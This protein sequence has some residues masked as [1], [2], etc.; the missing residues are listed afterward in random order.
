MLRKLAAPT[1]DAAALARVLGEPD[2]GGFEVNVLTDADSYQVTQAVEGL[3][4]D[5]E[6]SDLVLLHFSCHGIKDDSGEL[7]LAASN[8]V[9]N[10]LVSTAVDAAMVSRLIQRSR[11]QRVVLL[12][13]CCYGGAFERGVVARAGGEVD[14]GAQ[15]TQHS[16]PGGGRGRVV[17]TASSA[18]EYAF[19]GATL[20]DDSRGPTPSL[21]TG[22]LVEGITSGE[23]DRNQDG[24]VGLDEL[25]DYIHAKVQARTPNQ[26][27]C[28][29]EFGVQG[30][31]YIARNPR[32]KILPAQLPDELLEMVAHPNAS[33]RLAAVADLDRL[34]GGDN[35]RLAAAARLALQELRDDDSRRVSAAAIIAQERTTLRI[36]PTQI[37][38]G[39][40]PIGSRPH[41][42]VRVDGGPLAVASSIDVTHEHLNARF[43]GSILTVTATADQPGPL[44]GHVRLSG[45]AGEAT[46]HITG[47]VVDTHV[48]SE[49]GIAPPTSVPTE[50]SAPET[51]D[52][53]PLQ[54]VPTEEPATETA[55]SAPLQSVPTEE[56]GTE[57]DHTAEVIEAGV[58]SEVDVP[59]SGPV[60]VVDEEAGAAQ[61]LATADRD[62]PPPDTRVAQSEDRHRL[63]A[64]VLVAAVVVLLLAATLVA[65]LVTRSSDQTPRAD[66]TGTTPA[67]SPSEPTTTETTVPAPF[68]SA[69]L[70]E[71]A[72]Y[73]FDAHEC[74]PGGPQDTPLIWDLPHTELVKCDSGNPRYAGAF[75]CTHD[76]QDLQA[77]RRVYLNQAVDGTQRQVTGPPAG[78]DEPV[79]GVQVAFNHVSTND[80]RVYWDSPSLVCAGE[81]Q[82]END[83]VNATIDFWRNGS[84]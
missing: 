7:F 50:E 3:L 15:F 11:A 63:P 42:E 81:L 24:Q 12:L 53:A 34:A 17:I 71:F 65:L 23:A 55:D 20:T 30:D 78:K 18:M 60:E 40:V 52:S 4:G 21:F 68:Q 59:T 75:W 54:S 32:R 64:P 48:T 19:E 76:V 69:A 72:R 62:V 83:N 6:S 5:A 58:D 57:T 1:A 70:Y 14:V 2:L 16:S 77:D 26:T 51:A 49:I 36:T 28:K 45:P 74:G 9:P 37:D 22:A 33:V 13:D 29:W 79:D 80:A 67:T 66:G 82:A 56:P 41:V 10:R 61:S 84:S 35:L 38:L 43:E 44:D 73:L 46:V 25:Y 31:L 27:P 47:A 39:Q 8:T